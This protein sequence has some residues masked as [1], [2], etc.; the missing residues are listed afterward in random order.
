VGDDIEEVPDCTPEPVEVA[1]GPFP[2]FVEAGH[3]LAGA[4]VGE[5]GEVSDLRSRS[6]VRVG[7]PDRFNGQGF[8]SAHRW[9]TDMFSTSRNEV[10]S[11]CSGDVESTIRRRLCSFSKLTRTQLRRQEFSAAQLRFRRQVQTQPHTPRVSW[12]IFCASRE[13]SRLMNSL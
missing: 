11:F 5:L 7:K 3:G 4:L 2:Q 12:T 8:S 10:L 9:A 1:H 6:L 13:A